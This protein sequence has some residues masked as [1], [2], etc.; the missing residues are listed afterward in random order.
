[1]RLFWEVQGLWRRHPAPPPVNYQVSWIH[2]RGWSHRACWVCWGQQCPP[3]ICCRGP[4]V[5]RNTGRSKAKP[6]KRTFSEL[7][8]GSFSFWPQS[9]DSLSAFCRRQRWSQRWRTQNT[10]VCSSSW[11]A[12]K[13]MDCFK[14]QLGGENPSALVGRPLTCCWISGG[15]SPSWYGSDERLRRPAHA[16][17]SEIK[18]SWTL[19]LIRKIQAHHSNGKVVV[20]DLVGHRVSCLLRVIWDHLDAPAI[21]EH[22]LTCFNLPQ[23]LSQVWALIAW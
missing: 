5:S 16:D 20:D 7:R 21:H 8:N 10:K 19:N 2:P 23:D 3:R 22:Q 6:C 15:A 13:E 18:V 14:T 9:Q 11:N 12:K 1:M 4:R 17:T